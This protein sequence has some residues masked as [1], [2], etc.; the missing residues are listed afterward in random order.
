MATKPSIIDYT[1]VQANSYKS[2]DGQT[3]TKLSQKSSKPFR[4]LGESEMYS[5]LLKLN[6]PSII[7][8]FEIKVEATDK[9]ELVGEFQ[10]VPKKLCSLT[11]NIENMRGQ[12]IIEKNPEPGVYDHIE[13]R[14][15]NLL[16]T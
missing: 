8:Q 1:V 4:F 12:P 3:L 15:Q 14:L 9:V 10:K 2:R 13:I 7:T 5:L 6:K 16:P 11:L